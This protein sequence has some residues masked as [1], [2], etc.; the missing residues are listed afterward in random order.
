MTDVCLAFEVHQPLRIDRNFTEELARGRNPK[1]LLDIYFN[2]AWN[3]EIFQ[4]V[5]NKCY[6]PAN[7]II[8]ENIDRYK[9]ERRKFKVAFSI[10]GVALEQCARWAPDI[11]DSFKQLA[12]TGCVE[13]LC[14]TYFHSLSSLFSADRPEFVEQVLMYQ[15]LA[16]KL[17]GKKPQIFENTE[18]IYNN[19]IAKTIAGLG[20]RGIFTEG[21]ERVLGWRSPN[22]IYKAKNCDISVLLRN[23][24][25]SDD[26]SFRFSNRNWDGWPL[27]AD[28]YAMWLSTIPGQCINLFMDYE[29]FGEHQWPETGI[30]EFLRWL[31]G[32]ILNHEHL[33][34]STPSELLAHKPVGEIDVHDF[35]TVSWADV[36]RSVNA[37]L[38]NDMQRTAYNG[39]KKLEPFVK[40]TKNEVLL[41]VWRFMQTSDH[42][43]YMYTTSGPSGLVHGYFSQQFPAEAFWAFMRILSNFYEKIAENLSGEKRA[44]SYLLRIVPPDRAFHFH[45]DG[46]YI[47]LSAHNLEELRDTLQ[48][49]SDKSILFHVACKHFEKWVRFTIGDGKLADEISAIESKTASDLRQKLHQ[50]V[51]RRVEF[52]KELWE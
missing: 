47:N 9:S 20:F 34:F 24:R 26:V 27:T 28:K 12:K 42:I 25:L 5:A 37:W 3:R 44:S 11:L 1:E 10:S 39:V 7:E 23:Y 13:F 35:D 21:A 31:P 6:R 17:F 16:Q 32:E 52:L 2:N 29:T 14:Q 33:Q 50:T 45:E 4:R 15:N 48:L 38:G 22:F 49:A 43:Y 8:L 19:S 18:F 36:E 41:R 51:A 30:H 46:V 40:E